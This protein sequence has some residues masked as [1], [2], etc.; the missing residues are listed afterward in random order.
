M[1]LRDRLVLA[2]VT[3]L[4]ASCSKPS[5]TGETAPAGSS[6][7]PTVSA[8][9][10]AVMAPASA[11]SDQPPLPKHACK[12]QN[13]CKGQGGCKQPGKN[14]CRGRNACKGQGG[15]KTA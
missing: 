10:N 7:A 13:A 15:C 1:L 4:L 14:D 12:G 5:P 11:A 3:G 9:A 6:T 2:A 8:V